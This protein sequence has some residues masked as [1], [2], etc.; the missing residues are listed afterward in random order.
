MLAGVEKNRLRRINP[1]FNVR[2]DLLAKAKAYF[3]GKK[4]V[5]EAAEELH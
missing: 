5:V 1:V 3:R 4:Q 2:Y